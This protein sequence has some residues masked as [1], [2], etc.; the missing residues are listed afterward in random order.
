[1]TQQA[2]TALKLK[3]KNLNIHARLGGLKSCSYQSFLI[4]REKIAHAHA[5]KTAT[6]KIM[7]VRN[8]NITSQVH[9]KYIKVVVAKK[10]NI[11]MKKAW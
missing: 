2:P 10:E 3:L 4:I 6:I 5:H 7:F 11:K 8:V 1:M 9:V